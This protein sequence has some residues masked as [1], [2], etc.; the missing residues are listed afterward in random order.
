M[1]SLDLKSP[2]VQKN[3]LSA[4]LAGGAL[5]IFFFTHFLPFNFPNQ[6][7]RIEELKCHPGFYERPYV[8]EPYT[9]R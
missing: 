5:G 9:R 7:E 6:S 2:V 8:W 3:I 1:A 4:V